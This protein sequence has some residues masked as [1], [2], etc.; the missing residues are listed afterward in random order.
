MVSSNP[1]SIPGDNNGKPFAFSHRVE[2]VNGN[3]G[4]R[5]SLADVQAMTRDHFEGT[6][7][8][9]S[10]GA[11]AGPYNNPIRYD[12]NANI[13]NRGGYFERAISLHRTSYSFVAQVHPSIADKRVFFGLFNYFV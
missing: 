11:A 6:E 7:Y 2:A 13:A 4:A 1:S 9:L 3:L 8:D 5:L 10:V 12:R